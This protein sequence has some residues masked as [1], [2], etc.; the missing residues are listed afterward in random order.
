MFR[1]PTASVPKF[2][3]I[4]GL[5]ATALALS[6]ESALAA[7]QAAQLQ[8]IQQAYDIGEL[9]SL[10]QLSRELGA[11]R[12]PDAATRLAAGLADY[13]LASAAQRDAKREAARIEAAIARAEKTLAFFNEAA[14]A[15]LPAEQQAEGLAL[16]A[17]VWGLHIGMSP[18]QGMVLGPKAAAAVQKAVK[19]APQNP[20]VEL[21]RGIQLMFMP[22][23]FGGDRQE[24]LRAFER[25]ATLIPAAEASAANWGLADAWI[26][27]GLAQDG[28]KQPGEAR[29]AFQ[30]ALRVAPENRWAQHL[31]AQAAKP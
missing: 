15:A 19:L 12:E 6:T 21:A 7:V 3:L 25:V 14:G 11:Q 20:R 17:S 29:A 16:L 27:R 22:P 26:W 2:C 1:T 10:E 4:A 31:L 30:Q 13:R 24:A 23:M 18:V 9:D 5:L 28:L 8:R